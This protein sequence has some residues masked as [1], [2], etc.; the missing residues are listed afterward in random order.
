MEDGVSVYVDVDVREERSDEEGTDVGEQVP[1]LWPVPAPDVAEGDGGDPDHGQLV[2]ELVLV[3]EG[4]VEHEAAYS[5]G[6]KAQRYE[7]VQEAVAVLESGVDVV[8]G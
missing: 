2:H 5:D 8:G 4:G 1:R 6:G 7:D 3:P